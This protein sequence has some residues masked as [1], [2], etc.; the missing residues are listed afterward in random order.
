MS[1][2]LLFITATRIGDAVLSTGLLHHLIGR[3]PGARVTVAAG[4]LAAPLFEAVPG[5]ERTLI[6]EK[7]PF[8]LHWL[9][10]WGATALRRWDLAVDLRASAIGYL[11]PARRRLV[12]GSREQDRHRVEELGSLLGLDPPPEPTVWTAPRH[13]QAA[14]RL[15]PGDA[16]VLALGPA[17]NWVAK[18]WR[19]ERFAELAR[20]LTGPEGA[21]PGS[22]VAVLAAGH[23]RAQAGPVLDALPPAQRID[24]AGGIDLLTAAACLRRCSL[25]IGNDSGLMHLAAAAGA[26]TLGLFGPSSERRYGP[27]GA[28]TAHVRT[29]ESFE[30]H[31]AR[32]AELGQVRETLMDGLTVDAVAAAAED[33]LRRAGG[34]D[35]ENSLRAPGAGGQGG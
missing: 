8:K 28:A 4:R 29:P 30:D 23:E 27:W 20:R 24:L 10:L 32:C 12:V 15:I 35:P 9:D 3:H 18:Q 11:I 14:A 21:L 31:V 7:R 1:T 5:L 16:P 17:A 26:P 34:A 19:A 2:R 13:E 33:L 25:F 22:R 6:I